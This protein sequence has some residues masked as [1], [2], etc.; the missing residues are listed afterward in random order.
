[1]H[2]LDNKTINTLSYWHD[3]ERNIMVFSYKRKN[4]IYR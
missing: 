2:Y 3:G 1:V 4:Y